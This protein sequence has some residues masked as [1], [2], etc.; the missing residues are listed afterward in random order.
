MKMTGAVGSLLL[1]ALLPLPSHGEAQKSELK[2]AAAAKGPEE[3]EGSKTLAD[4][5]S[6]AAQ[7][8]AYLHEDRSRKAVGEVAEARR[9]LRGMRSA[10]QQPT[11]AE[12][13]LRDASRLLAAGKLFQADTALENAEQTLSALSG[14]ESPLQRAERN[15][16]QASRNYS[17]GR[18]PQA[19]AYLDKGAEYLAM[20]ARS[21]LTNARQEIVK[22]GGEI[23]K[24]KR[25]FDQGDKGKE[26]QSLWERGKA[27]GERSGDYLSAR[28]EQGSGKMV[29]ED[30][31]IEARLHVAYARSYQLTA[32]EPAE[33]VKELARAEAYLEK[34]RKERQNEPALRRKL[35]EL[36][37]ELAHLKQHAEKADADTQEEYE[38][39]RTQLKEIIENVK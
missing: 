38:S 10:G 26:L 4:A 1:I 14:G 13:T 16:R 6:H 31:L 24:L 3:K 19:K 30:D 35:A 27:L 8:R 29:G 15:L 36:L 22:L 12:Q 39:V 18:V 32:R 2:P 25:Q 5:A 34:A 7:A 17:T 20:A 9:L 23:G 21:G 37:K 33:T 28:V 11:A